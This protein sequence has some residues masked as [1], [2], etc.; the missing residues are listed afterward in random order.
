M[1]CHIE[2]GQVAQ[3]G[4]YLPVFDEYYE[5]QK[6]HG[7]FLNK[8]KITC[9]QQK[10]WKQ[11]FGCSNANLSEKNSRYETF[12]QKLGLKVNFGYLPMVR[13]R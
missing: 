12:Y 9:T 3:T 4:I 6:D 1:L 7:A 2:N 5:A 11:T 10:N 8:E 13:P